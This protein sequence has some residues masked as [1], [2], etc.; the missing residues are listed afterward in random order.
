[1]NI[2]DKILEQIN[3]IIQGI[4]VYCNPLSQDLEQCSFEK[5]G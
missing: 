2:M 1:M 4:T 5:Y 3:H